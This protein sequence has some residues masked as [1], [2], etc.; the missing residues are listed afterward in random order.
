MTPFEPVGAQ[1]IADRAS[2]EKDTIWKWRKRYADFPEPIQLA[3]GPVWEW[4]D[5][6]EWVERHRRPTLLY[7][8]LSDLP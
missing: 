6:A 2:V 1:E 4:C 5:V 3:M 8:A 7:P